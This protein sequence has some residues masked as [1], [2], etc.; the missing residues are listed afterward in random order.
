M[1]K[2]KETQDPQSSKNPLE[3]EQV[4]ST[5]KRFKELFMHEKA[6]NHIL[7]Q[8]FNERI[9][10]AELKVNLMSKKSKNFQN[11]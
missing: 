3:Q 11:F 9:K 7:F 5:I 8:E 10:V 6:A 1:F 4:Q 2:K